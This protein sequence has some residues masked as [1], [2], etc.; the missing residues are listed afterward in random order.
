MLT[1]EW[2]R[3]IYGGD[4]AL[5]QLKQELAEENVDIQLGRDDGPA[6]ADPAGHYA[7]PPPVEYIATMGAWIRGHVAI[8]DLIP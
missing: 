7:E 6:A 3:E 2:E 8:I 4:D 1:E 5:E